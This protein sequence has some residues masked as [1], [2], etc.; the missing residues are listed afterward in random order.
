[1]LIFWVWCIYWHTRERK[2]YHIS[3]S[4]LELIT[5]LNDEEGQRLHTLHRH[6]T[7]WG[8]PV[9]METCI[10]MAGMFLP[11]LILVPVEN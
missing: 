6:S 7:W 2:T 4:H 9:Y 5:G 11:L 1:M 3:F 8:W 10:S